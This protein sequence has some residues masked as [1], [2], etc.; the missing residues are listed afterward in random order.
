MK[1]TAAKLQ[2]Y[3]ESCQDKAFSWGEFDCCLFVGDWLQLLNGTDLAHDFRGHY[4]T[5]FSAF[6]HIKTL[7]FKDVEDVFKQRLKPI[8]TLYAKRGDVALVNY[9]DELVGGIIGL[10]C[11][12]CVCEH[13]ITQLPLSEIKTAFSCEVNV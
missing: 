1:H 7:G 6:K 5:Q 8:R 12:Y 13:G 3:L 2:S 11:V 9:R 4:S 10:N